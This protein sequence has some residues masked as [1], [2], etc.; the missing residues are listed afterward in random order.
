M[1]LIKKSEYTSMPWKNG[2]GL[3]EEIDRYPQQEKYLWR[4]SKATIKADGDF[5]LF[6]GY[7]RWICVVQGEDIFLN[8]TN[9]L[10]L[11]PFFFS[12]DLPTACKLTRGPVEDVG[13]IYDRSCM[14]AAM[15][16]VSRKINFSDEFDCHYLY[17]LDSGDTWKCDK[18]TSIEMQNGLLISLKFLN[19]VPS[20]HQT[21]R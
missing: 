3:T 4:L 11:N 20:S 19:S 15:Q 12:G 5:S 13:L 7:D 1:P 6:P 9:I 21:S 2:L 8:E 10:P 16:V 18:A 17:D 14:K